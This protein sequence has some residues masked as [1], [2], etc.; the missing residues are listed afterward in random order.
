[1]KAL[2]FGLGLALAGPAQAEETYLLTSISET[3]SYGVMVVAPTDGCRAVR[4]LIRD[5]R[6]VLGRSPTLGPGEMAVVRLGRGFAA[7]EHVLRIT[8]SGCAGSV[9]ARSVW[10][11]RVVLAKSSPDHGW[12]A[13]LAD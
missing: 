1:M 3:R 6:G 5:A 12:R 11:R 10:A 7:G 8:S 4:Y 2:A 13:G 9:G